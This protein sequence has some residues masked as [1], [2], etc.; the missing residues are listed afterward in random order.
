MKTMT[1]SMILTFLL[2]AGACVPAVATE[3]VSVLMT[4]PMDTP[5]P[6]PPPEELPEPPEP[7]DMNITK[8]QISPRHAHTELTPGESDE[9][10]VT[11]TNKDNVTVPVNPR[12]IDQPYSEYLFEEEWLTITP[13]SA[14]IE[15]DAEVEFTILF[16]IPDDA[17][18]GY[19][20]L[21]VAF[22][23]DVMP[24][25]YPSPYPMYLNALDLHISVWT[26][27]VM[28]IQPRY[29][30]DRVE[31]NRTYDYTINLKNMG[32]EDIKIDPKLKQDRGGHYEMGGPAFEDDA[33]TITAPQVV[34][35]GKTATVNVRLVVPLG[36]K[37]EYNSRVDLGIN[38]PSVDEW[39]QTVQLNFG[40]WTQPAT[41]YVKEFATETAAPITLEIESNQYRYDMCGGGSSENGEAEEPTFDVVLRGPT[42]DEV[43]LTKTAVEYRGSVN[44]GGSECT[45]PWEIDSSGMYNEGRTSYVERYIA[46]GAIGAWEL[47]ILPHYVEE[48]EYTIMIGDSET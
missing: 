12:V 18:R 38:D 10:T 16:E 4:V 19:Y 33:I 20:S 45:P 42:G 36:A 35:A 29:L 27:P 40:V 17:E 5:P 43:T 24:T 44:L 32:D 7:Y 39:D 21:Q 47:G 23:D 9:I 11:V 46:D 6:P 8:L 28:Q 30:H 22:T 1:V 31:S 15:P 2:I 48:F 3:E 26:L 37:G 41:P 13:E 34:P 25:P 14:E